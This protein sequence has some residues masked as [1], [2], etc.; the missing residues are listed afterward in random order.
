MKGKKVAV[1]IV[2]IAL[3]LVSGVLATSRSV[4]NSASR[5]PTLT[6]QFFSQSV[7]FVFTRMNF[8]ATCGS[9]FEIRMWNFT[10][11]MASRDPGSTWVAFKVF[12]GIGS[13][14]SLFKSHDVTPTLLSA[15]ICGTSKPTPAA[16]DMW[17]KTQALLAQSNGSGFLTWRPVISTS[18]TMLAFGGTL[19]TF[20]FLANETWTVTTIS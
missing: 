2:F 10:E 11:N 9:T 8:T 15:L 1:S 13:I 5:P 12:G 6:T 14:A 18:Y 19:T 4:V 17:N 20:P 7:S 3:I 16:L